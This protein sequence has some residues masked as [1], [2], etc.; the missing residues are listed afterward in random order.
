MDTNA[1]E[2]LAAAAV[3]PGMVLELVRDYETTLDR[4]R[5]IVLHQGRQIGHLDGLSS[6]L[7]AVEIDAGMDLSAVSGDTLTDIRP[8]RLEVVINR[9]LQTQALLF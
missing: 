2:E 6:A 7:L 3:T 5:I 9:N 4:N 8:I 1:G